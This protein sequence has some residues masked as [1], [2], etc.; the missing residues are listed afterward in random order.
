MNVF[1]AKESGS[2][3]VFAHA[4]PRN[5]SDSDEYAVARID[6]NIRW[7]GHTEITLK[8]DNGPAIR[9]L[10]KDSLKAARVEVDELEQVMGQHAVKY[11]S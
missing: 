5:G 1:A 2:Q 7:L 3:T 8:S 11:D 4:V 10:L 6:G 9:K